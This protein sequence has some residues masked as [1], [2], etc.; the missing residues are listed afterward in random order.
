MEEHLPDLPSMCKA[1]DWVLFYPCTIKKKRK[2]T[3]KSFF[4]DLSESELLRV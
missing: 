4:R 3:M 1:L 2:E